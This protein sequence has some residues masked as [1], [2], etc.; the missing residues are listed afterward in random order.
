MDSPLVEVSLP[1]PEVC[2]QSFLLY[3]S[4]CLYTVN[5]LCLIPQVSRASELDLAVGVRSIVVTAD[6]LLREAILPNK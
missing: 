4:H 6:A 3:C 1:L 2:F 5:I